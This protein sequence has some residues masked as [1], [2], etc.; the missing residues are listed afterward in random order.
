MRGRPGCPTGQEKNSV[1]ATGS[2]S[3]L[4]GKVGYR[5][6]PSQAALATGFFDQ[7][8]FSNRFRAFLGISPGAYRDSCAQRRDAYGNEPD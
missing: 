6:A 1:E 3:F 5:I 7:S 4:Q 8:H 2:T